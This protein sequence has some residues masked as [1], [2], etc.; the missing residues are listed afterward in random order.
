MTETAITSPT[1]ESTE[2]CPICLSF[3]KITM[4]NDDDQAWKCWNC[5]H[6][7]MWNWWDDIPQNDEEE[8]RVKFSLTEETW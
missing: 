8:K 1:D 4:V 2:Q 7:T 5:G 3:N 6:I